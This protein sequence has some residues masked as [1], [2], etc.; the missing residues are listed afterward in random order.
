SPTPAHGASYDA[1]FRGRSEAARDTASSAR[2]TQWQGQ[3]PSR[4]QPSALARRCAGDLD[5]VLVELA[6]PK[7]TRKH[8]APQLHL[9]RDVACGRALVRVRCSVEIQ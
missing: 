7:E 1:P 2:E 9:R 3:P 8:R 6:L 4:P 5:P